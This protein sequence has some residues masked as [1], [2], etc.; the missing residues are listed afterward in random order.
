VS[1]A[2]PR[3]D[4]LRRPHLD[5]AV[6]ELADDASGQAWN[7]WRDLPGDAA[8]RVHQRCQDGVELG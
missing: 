2:K 7:E 1:G 4:R 5:A 3:L 6:T 8:A